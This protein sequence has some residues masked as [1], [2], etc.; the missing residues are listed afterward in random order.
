MVRA[1]SRIT[2]G[3]FD[4]YEPPSRSARLESKLED[5]TSARQDPDE[6][7]RELARQ[8]NA[9]KISVEGLRIV[10]ASPSY[11]TTIPQFMDSFIEVQTVLRKY[12]TL[13]QIEPINAPKVAWIRLDTF[14]AATDEPIKI[15]KWRKLQKLLQRLNWIHPEVMPEEVK[16]I[17]Q[18]YKMQHNPYDRRPSPKYVDDMGR[19]MGVGRR[20]TSSAVAW[21]IE[22]EGEVLI[23]SKSLSQ[24]FTRIH[25]RESAIWAL[26]A[27]DRLDKYNLWALVRGGG[28]TGQAEALTLAVAKALMVHEPALKPVLRRAGCVTRDPRKVE[29]KKP[30]KLKAR[31][32]PAW[33][34][35]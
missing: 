1:Q 6:G 26:K 23:N 35:R 9:S 14:K 25:D 5:A 21:L 7:S 24:H 2:L 33:V 31:K 10:P 22:G 16:A 30:G 28:T 3:S 8:R 27:T 11:F 19:G 15:A 18:K 32:M 13:P 17:I 20:K 12:E 4:I 34:K 29:R